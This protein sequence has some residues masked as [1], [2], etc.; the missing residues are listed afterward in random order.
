[1]ASKTAAT[2][3]V[4]RKTVKKATKRAAKKV[5]AAA[6]SN[7]V[8][9][10]EVSGQPIGK[11]PARPPAYTGPIGELKTPKSPQHTMPE[12]QIVITRIKTEAIRIPIR[13]LSP[14]IT[15]KFSAKAKQQMLDAMQGNPQ[16]KKTKDPEQEYR[17]AAY[18]LDDGGFGLPSISFKNC[19]VSAARHW[20]KNVTMVG[21][22]QT[23][24]FRG[25]HSKIEGMQLARIDG[26]EYMRE[27]VV[28]VSNGGTDLRYRPC[29]PEWTSYIDVIYVK[30]ALTQDSVLSLV[31][32]GGLTVG[33]GE[34]RPEKRGEYG[35][36]CIREDVRVELLK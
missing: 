20:G 36:F 22:R 25:E 26:E 23:L 34:W 19:T 15:H 17:D 16:P 10:D 31:E 30:S 14:L 27:D 5:A 28:R 6:S 1:M 11:A 12:G 7:D 13:G 33:V 32:A 4:P 9:H 18:H 8:I 29:W 24:F 2:K 21:L 3:T 35:T